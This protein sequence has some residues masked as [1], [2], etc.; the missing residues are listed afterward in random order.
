MRSAQTL[1]ANI[2]H[3][4]Y[5]HSADNFNN[6]AE[7]DDRESSNPALAL[8]E[9]RRMAT[10][11]AVAAEAADSL[12]AVAV[13]GSFATSALMPE[14]KHTAGPSTAADGGAKALAKPPPP[15]TTG[16]VRA[17][18]SLKLATDVSTLSRQ[19]ADVQ[20]ALA[21]LLQRERG[22]A[23]VMDA[24]ASPSSRPL[25]GANSRRPRSSP[26]KTTKTPTAPSAQEQRAHHHHH[27]HQAPSLAVQESKLGAAADSKL[28]GAESKTVG[29]DDRFKQRSRRPMEEV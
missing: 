8:E 19:I 23:V 7:G 21:V 13:G 6:G 17:D 3:G 2:V 22:A 14:P 5:D 1:L 20:A 15:L 11:A 10:A 12:D 4:R 9:M 25:F 28:S 24:T 16:D 18:D 27:H 26:Q 29:A